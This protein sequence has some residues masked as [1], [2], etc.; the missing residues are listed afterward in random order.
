MNASPPYLLY[1]ATLNFA[2]DKKQVFAMVYRRL[3]SS[4]IIFKGHI[5]KVSAQKLIYTKILRYFMF[6]LA[7][8]EGKKQK[9]L[10][11][12]GKSAFAFFN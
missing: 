9:I 8:L 10:V 5:R 11:Y 4:L 6:I 2:D 7:W 12:I 3:N 1:V